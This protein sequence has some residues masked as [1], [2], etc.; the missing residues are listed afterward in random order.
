ME[1]KRIGS[2]PSSK[3]PGDWFTV[4]DFAAASKVP[5][6]HQPLKHVNKPPF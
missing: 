5:K 6:T 3:E 2:Q 4:C 1:I